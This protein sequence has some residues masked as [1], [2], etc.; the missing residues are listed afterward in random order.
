MGSSHQSNV[1]DSGAVNNKEVYLMLNE[2][3]LAMY[4]GTG[5]VQLFLLL[6]ERLEFKH[7]GSDVQEFSASHKI[8][9]ES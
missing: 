1:R 8:I 9:I 6:W 3:V 5:N 4:P 7:A 2:V